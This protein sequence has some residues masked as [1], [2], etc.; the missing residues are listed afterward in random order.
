[1]AK[2]G[3]DSGDLV[4]C[5]GHANPA[6]ADENTALG[7]TFDDGQSNRFGEVGI[8]GRLYAVCSKVEYFKPGISQRGDDLLLEMEAGV[9]R[10]DRD[11]HEA[12]VG[13]T[14][15]RDG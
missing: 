13:C 10:T 6:T 1:M 5:D 15:S 11:F 9:I 8:I 12:P 3:P 4:C 7:S 2:S 14:A